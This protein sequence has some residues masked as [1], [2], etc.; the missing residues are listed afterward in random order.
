MH[1]TNC[2]TEVKHCQ[3]CGTE[4]QQNIVSINSD[5]IL[6]LDKCITPT[7]DIFRDLCTS[8]DEN[9][10]V[11]KIC[12]CEKTCFNHENLEKIKNMKVLLHYVAKED[13]ADYQKGDIVYWDGKVKS[14]QHQW[15][16]I[17]DEKH[18]NFPDGHGGGGLADLDFY[19]DKRGFKIMC[20]ICPE[21]RIKWE[22][23]EIEILNQK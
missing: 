5:D 10:S 18:Y 16:K 4:L 23:G 17:K 6:K 20:A 15:F 21:V 14:C 3:N 7:T 1:C 9:K 11:L 13:G 22:D 8:Y 19:I 2:K 12:L